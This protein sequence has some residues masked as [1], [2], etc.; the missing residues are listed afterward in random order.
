[1]RFMDLDTGHMAVDMEA[2]ARAAPQ[3]ALAF[4]HRLPIHHPSAQLP[5]S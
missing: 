1:M 4:T 5:R 2:T 3:T